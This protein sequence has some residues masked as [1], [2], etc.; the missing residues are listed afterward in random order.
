MK[1]KKMPLGID[2]RVCVE[3]ATINHYIYVGRNVAKIVSGKP[4]DSVNSRKNFSSLFLEGTYVSKEF[5][6]MLQSFIEK[7]MP[8]L[9]RKNLFSSK[10]NAILAPMRHYS[11]SALRNIYDFSNEFVN[12]RITVLAT[13]ASSNAFTGHNIASLTNVL[14]DNEKKMLLTALIRSTVLT[15]SL[16]LSRITDD[17]DRITMGAM[18]NATRLFIFIED[19]AFSAEY[20]NYPDFFYQNGV[21]L[22]RKYYL[23]DGI[24]LKE[25]EDEILSEIFNGPPKFYR[26]VPYFS[27]ELYALVEELSKK[28]MLKV[29]ESRAPKVQPK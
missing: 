10:Y 2:F 24:R 8:E 28:Y 19:R 20:A 7:K 3:G 15:D 13:S 27:P 23:K 18:Y 17:G 11:V 9:E 26:T 22:L 14:T 12:H 6:L 16:M 21:V 29:A 1:A 4:S 5:M 25:T